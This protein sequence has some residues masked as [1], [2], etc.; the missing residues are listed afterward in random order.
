MVKVAAA[1]GAG[2]GP[3]DEEC[4]WALTTDDDRLIPKQSINPKTTATSCDVAADGDQ[5][6]VNAGLK[7]DRIM[8]R[9]AMFAEG[10][11]AQK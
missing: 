8:M 1:G 6:E 4:V 5:D 3:P 10:N 2:N 7:V 9:D 11:I